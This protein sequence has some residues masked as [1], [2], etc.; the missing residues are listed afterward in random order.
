MS[1]A[2]R[3]VALRRGNA[4]ASLSK[5]FYRDLSADLHRVNAG[6]D[7]LFVDMF[8]SVAVQAATCVTNELTLQ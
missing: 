1:L 7:T 2:M 5:T 4:C 8:N 3:T 6:Q